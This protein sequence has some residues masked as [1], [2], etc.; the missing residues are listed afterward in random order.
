MFTTSERSKVSISGLRG[1]FCMALA[2]LLILSVAL[3]ALAA[4]TGTIS[5]TVTDAVTHQPLPGVRVTAVAPTG[6]A[7]TVTDAHGFYSITGLQPDTYTV[8]YEFAGFQANVLTGVTVNAEQTL[9][10]NETIS[11]EL[12]TIGRV[13]ARSAGSAFQ[14]G[15]TTDTYTLTSQQIV[16]TQGKDNA[17]N[18]VT[19][20][21][22]LPGAQTDAS[23]Y[24]SL[25][26]GRENE[27][28]FEFEGINYDEPYSNQFANSLLLNGV[29]SLQVSPGAG[30]AS[31]GNSGTGVINLIAK[32]GTYPGFGMVS[33]E[34][35]SQTFYHDFIAEYGTATSD[36]RFSNYF[37]YIG[38]RQAELYGTNNSTLPE[39]GEYDGN[40]FN[41][42]N[43]YVDNAV[44]KFGK[45][46]SK[47][48]QAFYEG[49]VVQYSVGA[50]YSLGPNAFYRSGDPASLSTIAGY[51]N[52]GGVNFTPAEIGSLLSLYPGQRTQDQ[53]LNLRPD[54]K[55]VV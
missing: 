36:G 51:Y 3:P 34:V 44:F 10:L 30:D 49:Q 2:G 33:G 28:G 26:G 24:P 1:I 37:K 20:V 50:G 13:T 54:R 42:V 14:P 17:N 35:A 8:S 7:S 31:Q 19:L 4:L 48:I 47:S 16:T 38:Q 18:E 46:Q 5:G 6:R 53:Q 21:G 22:S 23:G 29:G 43:D 45:D 39:I 55:S 12:R 52:G 41:L 25:R 32:R 15:Q 9:Q 40:S 27:I 11:K